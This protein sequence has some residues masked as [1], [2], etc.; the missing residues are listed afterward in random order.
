MENSFMTHQDDRVDYSLERAQ[1]P[2]L[3][4]FL[5]TEIEQALPKDNLGL[6]FESL[7]NLI[8]M[9]GQRG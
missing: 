2:S 8:S 6:M 5:T 4:I 7:C 3:G 1:T 9:V